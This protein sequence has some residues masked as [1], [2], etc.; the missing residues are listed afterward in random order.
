MPYEVGNM[1][2]KSIIRTLHTL[3]RANSF[4]LKIATRMSKLIAFD[5]VAHESIRQNP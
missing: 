5:N 2:C 3:F 4:N 1:I